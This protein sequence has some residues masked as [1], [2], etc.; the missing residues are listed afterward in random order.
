MGRVNIVNGAIKPSGNNNMSL[1]DNKN[2]VDMYIDDLV[3]NHFLKNGYDIH[4]QM[5]SEWDKVADA[6]LNYF[7]QRLPEHLILYK[8]NQDYYIGLKRGY[9][10]YHPRF[11]FISINSTKK[12]NNSICIGE[13]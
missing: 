9:V 12:F 10:M 8:T 3:N 7:R 5:D 11:N 6:G 4:L 1:Q 13:L 2:Y